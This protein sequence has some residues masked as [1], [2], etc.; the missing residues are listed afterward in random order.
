MGRGRAEYGGGEGE[1]ESVGRRARQTGWSASAFKLGGFA[2]SQ[3]AQQDRSFAFSS[4][5][6]GCGRSEAVGSS[7]AGCGKERR[8]PLTEV[9]PRRLRGHQCACAV[10]RDVF[11]RQQ[12]GVA[13]WPAGLSDRAAPGTVVIATVRGRGR[14]WRERFLP[15]SRPCLADSFVHVFLCSLSPFSSLIVCLHWFVIFVPCGAARPLSVG[16]LPSLLMAGRLVCQ[17]SWD[18]C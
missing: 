11:P 2:R 9:L 4:L 18:R 7:L 16:E 6:K 14:L 1:G 15:F 10:C 17:A 12:R 3:R 13:R 8:G 5:H